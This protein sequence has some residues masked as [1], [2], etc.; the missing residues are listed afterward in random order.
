[1]FNLRK[2][3]RVL[4]PFCSQMRAWLD[5]TSSVESVVKEACEWISSLHC[6]PNPRNCQVLHP[7][8]RPWA[9]PY[10]L[11]K[12]RRITSLDHGNYSGSHLRINGS[13]D[14][15]VITLSIDDARPYKVVCAWHEIYHFQWQ[16]FFRG[17]T[18]WNQPGLDGPAER[19]KRQN[20]FEI[21]LE[22]CRRVVPR[23]GQNRRQRDFVIKMF[24]AAHGHAFEPGMPLD[25]MSEDKR[26]QYEYVGL[27]CYLADEEEMCCRAYAQALAK[28]S[29]NE[30][31]V[32]SSTELKPISLGK[33]GYEGERIEPNLSPAEL[34]NFHEE[35]ITLYR[36]IG[37]R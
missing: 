6:M 24:E 11:V 34:Q 20:Q 15:P 25:Q 18:I 29:Q 19:E 35:L 17:L 4:P 14:T 37:W 23:F 27:V 7:D 9:T 16:E 22:V 10:V 31:Y 3:S 26:A 1:M 33:Y 12:E 28:E 5:P 2:K 8:G 21:F 30:A 36:L 13:F 32:R